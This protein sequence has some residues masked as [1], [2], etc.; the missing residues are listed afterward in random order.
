ML[1]VC[2]HSRD[3]AIVTNF[4]HEL[5]Y[6]PSFCVLA[7]HNGWEDRNMDARINTADDPSMLDKNV[8]NFGPVHAGLCDTF[9]FNHIRQMAPIV[10]AELG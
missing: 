8:V 2:S 7:F 10:D 1:P 3:V 9:Q 6:P 5:A 4:W